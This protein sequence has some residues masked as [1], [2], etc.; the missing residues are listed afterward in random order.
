M[1]AIIQRVNS[2]SVTVG[3]QTIGTIQKGLLVLLG[4]TQTDTEDEAKWMVEKIVN[5]RLFPQGEQEFDLSVL[6]AKLEIL[7]VS[8]FTL[9]G[10]CDKGRRP[11]FANASRPDHSKP[12]YEKTVELLRATNLNIQTGEFGA[13]MMVSLVNDGPATFTLERNHPTSNA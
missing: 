13:H 4:I 10:S 6:D 1:K 12:L 3:A 2:A 9:Y 5:L 7:I 8:Q 11:D